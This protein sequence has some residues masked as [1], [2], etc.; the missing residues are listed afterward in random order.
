MRSVFADAGYW[1]ALLNRQ[2]QLHEKAK[3]VSATLGPVRIVTSEMILTEVLN[4]LAHLGSSVREAA[5]QLVDSLRKDPNV[6]I[7]PQT[8]KLFQRAHRRY[9]ERLD[10]EWGLVD[11]ATLLL[12][13]DEGVTEILAHDH[14][15]EQAGCTALLR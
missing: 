5:A 10:K 8:S 7:H 2:D 1:I 12:M 6:T 15:F 11:C 14:H 4:G 3:A 13:E 9:A